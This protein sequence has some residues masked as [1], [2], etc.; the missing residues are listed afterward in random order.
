MPRC[1][2]TSL[3]FLVLLGKVF[4][5]PCWRETHLSQRRG[6]ARNFPIILDQTAPHSADRNAFEHR[7]PLT[8]PLEGGQIA[9][10]IACVTHTV[11]FNGIM[12]VP[13]EI[14]RIAPEIIAD[15]ARNL[16]AL[17]RP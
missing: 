10:H 4:C 8:R 6:L 15:Q 13:S 3:Q 7:A 12:D 9:E 5:N 17:E 1:L 2:R 14:P 16:I 11:G